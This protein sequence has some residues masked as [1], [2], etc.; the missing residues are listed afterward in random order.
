M[1]I[2]L[3]MW[4]EPNID[5][6]ACNISN[7]HIYKY[8]N[9]SIRIYPYKTELDLPRVRLDSRLNNRLAH[10]MLFISVPFRPFMPFFPVFWL[11]KR[12]TV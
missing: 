8:N 5:I 7:V 1:Y 12:S 3:C 4:K 11:F 10:L 9:L 2:Y 6:Y